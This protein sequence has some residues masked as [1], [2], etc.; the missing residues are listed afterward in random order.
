[1]QGTFQ[2]KG[3]NRHELGIQY[4]IYR[5]PWLTN[6]NKVLHTFS[7]M[8]PIQ[9]CNVYYF[10]WKYV[11]VLEKCFLQP[12]RCLMSDWRISHVCCTYTYTNML[13]WKCRCMS[14]TLLLQHKDKWKPLSCQQSISETLLNSACMQTTF[15]FSKWKPPLQPFTPKKALY[16]EA[17]M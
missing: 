12:L 7:H 8:H 3:I 14:L 11:A 17:G 5:M 4:C 6:Q 2:N 1:M 10:T 15:Y 16:R 13:F 9:I